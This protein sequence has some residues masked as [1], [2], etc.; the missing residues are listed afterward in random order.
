M[1]ESGTPPHDQLMS[2]RACWP[3][4][5][6]L[7]RLLGI[8]RGRSPGRGRRWPDFGRG[9]DRACWR[10]WTPRTGARRYRP[11]RR[12]CRGRHRS[13]GRPMTPGPRQAVRPAMRL[14]PRA[15]R[16]PGS[17]PARRPRPRSRSPR[18]H[19]GAASR[20]RSDRHVRIARQIAPFP[21]RG[22]RPSAG[23]YAAPPSRQERRPPYSQSLSVTRPSLSVND[24][25][26]RPIM[27]WG[28]PRLS[29]DRTAPAATDRPC[30]LQGR[31][32]D[33][34]FSLFRLWPISRSVA[35]FRAAHRLSRG[36]RVP[37]RLPWCSTRKRWRPSV[38]G[39]R[40]RRRPTGDREWRDNGPWPTRSAAWMSRPPSSGA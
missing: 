13:R 29:D 30:H 26:R 12:T 14:R 36:P 1:S 27:Q 5:T 11:G 40:G 34:E 33:L 18:H 28:N 17:P 10:C 9:G 16:R 24:N 21:V 38:G 8:W 39:G 7:R 19:R 31:T 37:H 15:C 23:S 35:E 25:D 4:T 2:G 20:G 22:P 6:W 32:D 3:Y